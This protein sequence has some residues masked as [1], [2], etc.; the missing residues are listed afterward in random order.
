MRF[1]TNLLAET[2]YSY[3]RQEVSFGELFEKAAGLKEGIAYTYDTEIVAIQS[4]TCPQLLPF[5]VAVWMAGKIPALLHPRFPAAARMK[6]LEQLNVGSFICG[7]ELRTRV[8]L[9]E[10]HYGQKVGEVANLEFSD[11]KLASIVFTSGSSGQPKAVAHTFANHYWSALG[12]HK[13]TPFERGMSWAASLP[14]CHVG[15]LSLFFRSLIRGGAIAFLDD[16]LP[17]ADALSAA[18][19]T[20]LSLVPAQLEL[21]LDSH[22]DLLRGLDCLLIGGA[23]MGDVLFQKCVDLEI[24]VRLT[25]GMTE[26]ASQ[27]ATANVLEKNCGKVLDFRGLKI[28]ASEILIGGQTLFAGYY[29]KGLFVK[30]IGDWFTTGDLGHFDKDGNLLVEGRKDN[31][32]ISGG[33]NIQPEEIEDILLTLGLFSQCFVVPVKDEKFGSRPFVFVDKTLS[34]D[35]LHLLLEDKLPKFMWPVGIAKLPPKSGLKYSRKDLQDLAVPQKKE[36]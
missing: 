18:K 20:H 27:V 2:A 10:G 32:F 35:R 26:S 24:P 14:M 17:F 1:D 9:V 8:D 12:A 22:V 30:R 29:E 5:I 33:E 13:N 28:N 16:A 3:R 15:G 19:A 36:V 25:Y 11:S 6:N 21:L 7:K 31:M 34:L 23:P 4:Q